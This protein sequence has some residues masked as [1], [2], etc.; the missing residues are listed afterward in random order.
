MDRR[1]I[2]EDDEKWILKRAIKAR[3]ETQVGLAKKMGLKQ[4]GLNSNINRSRMS[5]SNFKR[6]LDALG[7][8][9]VIVDRADGEAKWRLSGDDDEII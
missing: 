1:D 3:G 6:C 5:V 8:D 2:I 4:A 9:I 7:Y